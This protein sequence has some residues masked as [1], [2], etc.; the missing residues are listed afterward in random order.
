MET[1][2]VSLQDTGTD[3]LRLS[4]D[5]TSLLEDDTSDE[6]ITSSE[7]INSN[8]LNTSD[9]VTTT[10]QIYTFQEGTPVLTVEAFNDIVQGGRNKSPILIGDTDQEFF[11]IK[12]QGFAQCMQRFDN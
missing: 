5:I 12:E 10:D 8:E 1:N 4:D 6:H 2:T 3:Q 7:H 11:R 9:P